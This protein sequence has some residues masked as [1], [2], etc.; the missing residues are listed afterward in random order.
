MPVQQTHL[1]HFNIKLGGSQAPR[2]MMDALLECTVE[3][4]MHLPDMCTIRL[5][6]PLFKWA[7]DTVIA[8]GKPVVIE[9]GEEKKPLIPIFEGE[10]T[11]LELDMAAQ[12]HPTLVIRCMSKLHRLHRGRYARS[13]A[14]VSDSDLARRVGSEAGFTVDADS[15]NVVHAW[16]FQNNQTNWEF[17][18]DRAARCGHRLYMDGANKLCFKKIDSARPGQGVTLTWGEN[19]R[20][21]RP[22]TAASPQ[23]DEV[24][25]RGWDPITKKAI[26]G[27]ST[28][29][30]NLPATGLSPG[31]Q[32]GRKAFSS[33]AKMVVVDHPVQS[34]SEADALAG[35][36]LD[37]ITG[38][39]LEAEG[40]CYGEPKLIPGKKVTVEKVGTRFSG[41]YYV[42]A[43]THV[44]T[45]AEGYTTLF[46]ITGKQ[47]ETLFSL[48]E[49]TKEATRAQL[50][51]NILIGI[52][53]NNDDPEKM[54][55]VKV[56]YPCL[57]EEHESHWVRIA[58]QMAGNGRG[59]F[60]LPEV[61]DEVLV[62]FE[63]GDIHRPFILGQLWNGKDKF[64]TVTGE[65]MLKGGEVN[66]RGYYTRIGHQLVFDDT[67]R[68]GEIRLKTCNNHVIV[69]DDANKKIEVTTKDGHK[70]LM[71]DGGNKVVV[72]DKNG[73][74]LTI[75]S[76]DNSISME[77]KGNFSIDA[78]GKVSIK[79]LQGIDVKTPA[80]MTLEGTASGTVKSTGI[81]TVQGSLVKIN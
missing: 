58:S 5:D 25:V 12:G 8:E 68:K 55:R 29:G 21:F 46:A 78:K 30:R 41:T 47:P 43:T 18:C 67:N 66:R 48:V 36:V 20:S 60:N 80:S 17:L 76:P 52:V 26:V 2:Q 70:V 35:S 81:L 40:L 65:P 73:N 19:L 6:D 42:S 50:G 23:V 11:G 7:D 32:A 74:K 1:S 15:T 4:S 37:T 69:M 53:T 27:R 13:F 72:T 24:I 62:A 3:N 79:G 44:Y 51:G 14:N 54:G 9:A 71:D 33:A 49:E 39:Y 45:P 28:V 63:H 57:T 75:N 77:C 38:S 64:P 56:K 34:Q 22:R 59:M 61:N 31:T 16:V 10:I